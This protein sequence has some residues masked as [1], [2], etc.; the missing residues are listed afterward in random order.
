M[1]KQIDWNYLD[2]Q[3]LFPGTYYLYQLDLNTLKPTIKSHIKS[4]LPKYI[5]SKIDIKK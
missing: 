2:N 3:H 1:F 5:T 4:E